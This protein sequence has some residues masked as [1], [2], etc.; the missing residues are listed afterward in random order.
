MITD[1]TS[2]QHHVTV[3]RVFQSALPVDG[4]VGLFSLFSIN[5]AGKQAKGFCT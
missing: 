5:H 4:S 3:P 1:Q 2:P